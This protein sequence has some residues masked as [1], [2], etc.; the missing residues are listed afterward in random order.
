[1]KTLTKHS[2]ISL[3]LI[4]AL[5]IKPVIAYENEEL[6]NASS[7][8]T[9]TAN[10]KAGIGFGVGAV[11]GAVFGG[12]AGAFITGLAG[13]LIAKEIN[14]KEEITH[15]NE[16]I[17]RT[18][19]DKTLVEQR[20]QQKLAKQAQSYRQQ[21][22]QFREKLD[23]TTQLQAQNLLMSLQ[24]STG[25]SEIKDHYQPQITALANLLNQSKHLDVDLSGYTDLQGDKEKNHA[26][27]IARVNAVKNALINQ[28][29]KPERIKLFAFGE[30]APVVANQQQE[31][32]FYDRRVVIKLRGEQP[33]NDQTVANHY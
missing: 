22:A 23:E 26:L 16:T 21:I 9:L 17:A 18:E 25:S 5:S 8:T 19:Q 13:N 31:V 24:F 28:G 32:S 2:L 10:D 15:L 29:V 6:T 3:A 11:I 7:E 4:S 14:A 1:M 27:S 30:E 12:P 33:T 20:Y